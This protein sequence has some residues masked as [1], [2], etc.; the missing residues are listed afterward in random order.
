[1]KPLIKPGPFFWY[2]GLSQIVFG[3]LRLTGPGASTADYNI[4]LGL[5]VMFLSRIERVDERSRALKSSS[6]HIAFLLAYVILVVISAL[7]GYG[8]ISYELIKINHFLILVFALA[9][10][11]YYSRLYITTSITGKN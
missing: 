6:L 3:L 1:M 11:I 5:Y 9:L 2:L 7:F 8:V 4:M 10:I